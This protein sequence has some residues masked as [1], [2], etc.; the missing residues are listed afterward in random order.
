[1]FH[2]SSQAGKQ[3]KISEKMS[4]KHL[5]FLCVSCYTDKRSPIT[6]VYNL[7]NFGL[8]LSLFSSR[9]LFTDFMLAVSIFTLKILKPYI[10]GW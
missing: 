8:L 3:R 1:M 10:V 7:C 6:T 2:I 9:K 5:H 4:A